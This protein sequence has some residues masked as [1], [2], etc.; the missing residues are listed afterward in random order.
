MP[1]NN[2]TVCVCKPTYF[3]DG[4][5]QCVSCNMLGCLNCES[6]HLC[7]LC[8]DANNYILTE[9]SC[10]KIIE[11]SNFIYTQSHSGLY[12]QFKN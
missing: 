8:D 12:V 11:D 3:E 1:I 9:S 7:V 10:K 6:E 4:V 5:G 2:G